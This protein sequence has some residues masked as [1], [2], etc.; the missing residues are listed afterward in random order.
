MRDLGFGGNHDD[1]GPV[2]AERRVEFLGQ[3]FGSST[4]AAWQPKPTASDSISSPGRSRP[5]T[6]G[7]FSS[8][9]NDFKTEYSPLRIT[10]NTMGSLCCAAVQIA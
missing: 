9:A 6:L 4:V 2:R 7:V 10:T 1:G 8:S 3:L 5:G